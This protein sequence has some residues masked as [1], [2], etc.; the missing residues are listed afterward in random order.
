MNKQIFFGFVIFS[1]A[2]M[3]MTAQ[4][5]LAYANDLDCVNET[6]T[7]NI[8]N[9]IRIP[10]DPDGFGPDLIED[11]ADDGLNV[12]IY[13]NLDH[14]GNVF[15]EDNASLHVTGGSE[16]D[17]DLKV[18]GKYSA[19]NFETSYETDVDGNLILDEN[20]KAIPVIN[21]KKGNI[22]LLHED[23]YGLI[24]ALNLDGNINGKGELYIISNPDRVTGSVFIDGNVLLDANGDSE[25]RVD[26]G[27]I[28]GNLRVFKNHSYVIND[29]IIG[30]NLD[31]KD[32]FNGVGSD[33][34]E[35]SIYVIEN[36]DIGGNFN[37]QDN[38]LQDN[39][40]PVATINGNDVGGN[41]ICKNNDGTIS[42]DSSTNWVGGKAKNDCKNLFDKPSQNFP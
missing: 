10:E 12:C 38:T 14:K 28:T 19:I 42:G 7:G 32:A 2:G 16:L 6:L 39:P 41:A 33:F 11:T 17:G 26:G 25:L 34:D 18:E 40:L 15:I 5:P 35:T 9:N 3:M 4:M 30:G 24:T 23:S 27:E 20:G 22:Q 31:I 29:A 1:L 8:Q 13:D 21:F 36:N 37:F